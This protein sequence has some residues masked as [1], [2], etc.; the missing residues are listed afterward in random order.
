MQMPEKIIINCVE[1]TANDLWQFRID[2]L[3]FW[4]TIS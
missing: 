2:V 4:V 3:Q 1:K